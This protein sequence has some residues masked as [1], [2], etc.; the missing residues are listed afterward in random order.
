MNANLVAVDLRSHTIAHH[1][2]AQKKTHDRKSGVGCD[3]GLAGDFWRG[4]AQDE[5]C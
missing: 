4:N 5:T 1:T 3:A 2:R